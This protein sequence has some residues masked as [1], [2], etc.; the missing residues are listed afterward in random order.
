VTAR[1]K[2]AGAPTSLI[3]AFTEHGLRSAANN[4]EAAAKFHRRI[5][6]LISSSGTPRRRVSV[7][8]LDARP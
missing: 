7:V 5:I 8:F 2:V 3:L 4:D 6:F 1:E